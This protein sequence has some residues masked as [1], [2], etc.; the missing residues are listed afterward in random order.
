[1]MKLLNFFNLLGATAEELFA[2]AP[3]GI[4]EIMIA[5]HGVINSIIV[6][7]I[8]LVATVAIVYAIVL[9]VNYA[10]AETSDAKEEAKKRIINMVVGALLMIVLILLLYLFINNAGNIFKWVDETAGNPTGAIRNLF[11]R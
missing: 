6:P 3:G 8:I 2:N 5:V 1:M 11:V 7:V 4:K 9:G 10:K